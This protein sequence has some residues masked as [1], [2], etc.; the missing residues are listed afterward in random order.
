MQVT[1]PLL[2]TLTRKS[3][4]AWNNTATSTVAAALN[5]QG[6]KTAASTGSRGRCAPRV[7][8]VRAVDRDDAG[9]AVS[10]GACVRGP[11]EDRRPSRRIRRPGDRRLRP[12]RIR[13]VVFENPGDTPVSGVDGQEDPGHRAVDRRPLR[14]GHRRAVD[15]RR[16]GRSGG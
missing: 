9:S 13:R 10:D 4:A 1:Y 2:T 14:R 6:G 16:P 8:R 7:Q 11:E 12:R 3:A 5:W 15:L